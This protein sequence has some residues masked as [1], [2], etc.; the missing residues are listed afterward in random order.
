MGFA[1]L[2]PSYL[3][4]VQLFLLVHAGHRADAPLERQVL[5][6]DAGAP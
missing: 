3:F 1:A 2:Y 5:R 4:L 6:H